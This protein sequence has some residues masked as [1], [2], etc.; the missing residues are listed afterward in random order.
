MDMNSIKIAA[1]AYLASTRANVL[2]VNSSTLTLA[3]A[4]ATQ[5]L[6]QLMST[7]RPTDADA[8]HRFAPRLK[9]STTLTSLLQLQLVT[10]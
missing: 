2:K 1:D 6:A 4:L 5:S 3:L 10:S 9:L 7:G 8:S